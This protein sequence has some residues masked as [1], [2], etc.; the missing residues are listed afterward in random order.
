[1]TLYREERYEVKVSRTVLKTSLDWK[2]FRFS[3]T[4]LAQKHH[5]KGVISQVTNPI[6]QHITLNKFGYE[7]LD[8]ISYQD[9]EYQ[10]RKILSSITETDSCKLVIKYL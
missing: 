4:Q 10:G 7:E 2:Q 6:S 9:F 1:M 3:L 5:F 8:A